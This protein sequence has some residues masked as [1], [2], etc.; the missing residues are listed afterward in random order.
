MWVPGVKVPDAVEVV[1]SSKTPSLSVSQ[2]REAIVP[3]ESV[4]VSVKVK[5]T[6]WPVWGLGGA[7]VKE[8]V[9]GAL[10]GGPPD[11]VTWR[12]VVAGAP[13]SSVTRR[14]TVWVP[15]V[16]VPDAVVRADVEDAVVVGV[17]GPRGDR[18]VGVGRGVGEGEGDLLAGLGAG[19]GDREGGRRRPRWAAG[20][21]RPP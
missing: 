17:P 9:G 11:T 18:P 13:S 14:R 2:A 10:V 8:A 20:C 21:P 1:P 15:G 19:G 7:T 3:S 12:V 5:V 16:K 6:C 4:E